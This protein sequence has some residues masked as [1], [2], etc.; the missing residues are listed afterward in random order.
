[1]NRLLVFNR[2]PE[3]WTGVPSEGSCI[4]IILEPNGGVHKSLTLNSSGNFSYNLGGHAYSW[5]RTITF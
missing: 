4:I 3:D 5:S 1:M 2:K